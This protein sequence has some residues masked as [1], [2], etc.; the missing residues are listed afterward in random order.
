M[1][2][3]P[4]GNTDTRYYDLLGVSKT[5]S[6]EE[7]KKAYRKLALSTHPDKGGDPEKFKDIGHAYQIL[8]DE[9]H[10]QAYDQFGENAEQ[11]GG[12]Q[13]AEDV[14]SQF[15]S[16]GGG[17]FPFGGS[18]FGG[19]DE[20]E[21]RSQVPCHD[22]KLDLSQL[23]RGVKIKTKVP[24]LLKCTAC[25][26]LGKVTMM[27]QM[28]PFMTQSAQACQTCGG[29]GMCATGEYKSI[30]LR[31]PKG[32]ENNTILQVDGVHLKV[33]QK[34]H[35]LFKRKGRH[36]FIERNIS[37]VE[38]LTGFQMEIKHLDG[39]ML[40]IRS[41]EIIKPGDVMKITHQGMPSDRPTTGDLFIIFDVVFPRQ[42][43]QPD[44]IATVFNHKLQPPKK[45][46]HVLERTRLPNSTR[47][48]E[49]E[50]R[51]QCAQQ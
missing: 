13:N 6:Q 28:G 33:Q 27:R 31:I 20:R 37:L 43:V 34:P 48:E 24:H 4:K 45:D 29:E 1:F 11:G 10:R 3:M 36:L 12:F 51:P 2:N 32:V 35:E 5:A 16:G 15:F 17:G 40:S 46:A 7:I 30:E 9:K 22:L 44:V 25:N 39:K 21:A 19:N 14:F 41:N 26:G 47:G 50:G 18:P 38:A 23:Y 8:S 42:I 49:E